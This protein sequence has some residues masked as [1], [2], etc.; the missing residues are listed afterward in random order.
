MGSLF[1]NDMAQ[2]LEGEQEIPALLETKQDGPVIKELV[3]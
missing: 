2:K 1:L 3:G